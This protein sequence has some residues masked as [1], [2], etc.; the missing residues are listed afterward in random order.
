MW[1]SNELFSRL[2]CASREEYFSEVLG[3]FRA[4][5]PLA[6]ASGFVGFGRGSIGLDKRMGPHLTLQLLA[7]VPPSA[8]SYVSLLQ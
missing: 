5:R 4:Q 3:E 7:V 8:L 6:S 2:F 1:R